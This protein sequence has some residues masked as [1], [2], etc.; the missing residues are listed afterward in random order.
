MSAHSLTTTKTRISCTP[1]YPCQH[2][3][4]CHPRIHGQTQ[5]METLQLLPGNAAVTSSIT[6]ATTLTVLLV[7]QH[8]EQYVR[9]RRTATAP[10]PSTPAPLHHD[11][12]AGIAAAQQAGRADHTEAAL[13]ARCRLHAG[14]HIQHGQSDLARQAR[15]IRNGEIGAQFAAQPRGHRA[16]AT[17]VVACI[18][19]RCRSSRGGR[20]SRC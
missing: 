20:A 15:R 6:T 1:H 19:A 13:R 2:V 9:A 5:S 8:A 4:D 3:F 12:G 11:A 14:G 16:D 18:A 17:G 10:L 7:G